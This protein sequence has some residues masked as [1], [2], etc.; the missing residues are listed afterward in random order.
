M[1]FFSLFSVF[2]F[3]FFFFFNFILKF[4]GT[5]KIFLL[6]AQGS[7]Y[8]I[9]SSYVDAIIQEFNLGISSYVSITLLCKLCSCMVCTPPPPFQLG[10]GEVRIFRKVFAWGRFQNFYFGGEGSSFVGGEGGHIILK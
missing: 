8:I 7:F 5:L 6:S 10:G 2:F 9:L 4:T 3:F 1:L